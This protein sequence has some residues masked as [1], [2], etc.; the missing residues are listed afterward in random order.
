MQREAAR[1]WVGSSAAEPGCRNA[2]AAGSQ[3]HV[4]E[5]ADWLNQIELWLSMTERDIIARGIF[6]STA[7]LS[8]KLLRYI[9]LHNKTAKPIKW[10]YTDVT[11]R[12]PCSTFRCYGPPI[13]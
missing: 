12:F 10:K 6:T 5:A 8:R 2:K 9:R 4:G 7:D 3:H 13:G 11:R 1:R